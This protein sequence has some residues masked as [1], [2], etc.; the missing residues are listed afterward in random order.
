MFRS[1]VEVYFFCDIFYV[2]LCFY[3]ISTFSILLGEGPVH[4]DLST[5]S[6]DPKVF[7]TMVSFLYN[8]RSLQ[9]SKSSYLCRP[10]SCVSNL[11]RLIK[12]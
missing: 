2:F 8:I 12:V 6:G 5:A 1:T 4:D 10:D 9:D 7:G 11:S 3:S